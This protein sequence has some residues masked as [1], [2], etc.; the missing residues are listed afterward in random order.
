MNQAFGRITGLWPF[1][2]GVYQA[3][4]TNNNHSCLIVLPVHPTVS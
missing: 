1:D 2:V 3:E 4:S